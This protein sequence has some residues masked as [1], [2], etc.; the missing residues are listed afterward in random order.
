MRVGDLVRIKKNSNLVS[1]WMIEA[2]DSGAP[3]LIIKE[4]IG[5][6][7]SE[8]QLIYDVIYKGKTMS[9]FAAALERLSNASR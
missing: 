2:R 5:G 1:Y 9:V 7:K 8:P 6:N 4:K 3:L